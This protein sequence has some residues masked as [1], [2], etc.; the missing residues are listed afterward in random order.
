MLPKIVNEASETEIYRYFRPKFYN[1]KKSVIDTC[2][3][4]GVMFLFSGTDKHYDFWINVV[5]NDKAFS[6]KT[7]KDVLQK[8]K[9][10]RKPDGTVDISN[11]LLLDQSILALLDQ[12]PN[13]ELNKMMIN[14]LL[15]HETALI[16]KE[17][18]SKK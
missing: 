6:I 4:G 17:K 14:I 1:K 8:A 18:Y 15:S 12:N 16:D 13:T 3:F 5:P 11:F 2:K 7:G 10:T 9:N